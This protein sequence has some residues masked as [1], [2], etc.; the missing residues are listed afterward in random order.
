MSKIVQDVNFR[1]H[2]ILESKTNAEEW[3]KECERASSRLKIQAGGDT[4][5]WRT[6]L[7]QAKTYGE[8]KYE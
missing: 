4:K 2:N 3:Q 7:E 1:E 8:V 5:E 6:H